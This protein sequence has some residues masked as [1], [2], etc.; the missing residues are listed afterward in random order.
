MKASRSLED[1]KVLRIFSVC[2]PYILCIKSYAE[3]VKKAERNR[4]RKSRKAGYGEGRGGSYE[5]I[6]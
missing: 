4:E 5:G 6:N 1:S 2:S 3:S